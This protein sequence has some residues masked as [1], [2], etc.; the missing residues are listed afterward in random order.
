M[1]HRLNSRYGDFIVPEIGKFT[2]SRLRHILVL[3]N[4]DTAMT[5]RTQTQA[6]EALRGIAAQ[7][8]AA[9][10]APP[11]M[12]SE[13]A[14]VRSPVVRLGRPPAPEETMQI[15]LRLPKAW[16]ARLR[17][18]ALEASAAEERTITPQE[19]VRRLVGQGLGLGG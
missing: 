12:P 15:S 13:P 9:S 3:S 6:L 10:V 2:S 17:R 14:P 1:W 16:H 8:P 5:K 18:H 7:V 19:I 4:W 11:V